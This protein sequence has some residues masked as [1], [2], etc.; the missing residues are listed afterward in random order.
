MSS[1]SRNIHHPTS[2]KRDWREMN[3]D[4]DNDL[5]P[6]HPL[7][8]GLFNPPADDDYKEGDEERDDED[9]IDDEELEHIKALKSIFKKRRK[10]SSKAQVNLEVVIMEN[11]NVIKS[12][13]HANEKLEMSN[14]QLKRRITELEEAKT[15]GNEMKM[16]NE[17]L[18]Q[19]IATFTQSIENLK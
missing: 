6:G 11:K 7:R 19:T 2:N 14:K 17:R 3:E 5:P 8:G 9:Y 18:M 1:S 12:L 16:Q 15:N 13:R 4:E 10:S